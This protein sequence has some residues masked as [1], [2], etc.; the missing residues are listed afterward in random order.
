MARTVS[1]SIASA[2]IYALNPAKPFEVDANGMPKANVEFAA[3][4]NPSPNKARILAEKYCKT[5]NVMVLRVEVDE[6]K[7]SVNP[8]VFITN[9]EICKDGATY[10]REYITQ[11]FKI[12]TLQGFYMDEKGMHQ[13]TDIYN[14][15]TTDNKLLNYARD[16]FGQTT[17]ITAKKVVDERRFMTRE[18]YMEL[19][20]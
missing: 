4:G 19:A 3:D 20:R 12:T 13:F 8:E 5:K 6:T 7:L 10:G 16:L 15:E 2:T 9:S 18:R 14:G 11:T 1:K 17:V